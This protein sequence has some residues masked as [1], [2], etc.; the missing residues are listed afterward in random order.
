MKLQ[1]I[2]KRAGV[3]VL[4][5]ALSLYAVPSAS[6]R[7]GAVPQEQNAPRSNSNHEDSRANQV[8]RGWLGIGIKDV[9]ADQVSQL[10]L[11]A[12]GG[13]FV[14]EVAENSPAAK[15]G[16]KSGDVVTEYNGQHVDNAAQFRTLVRQTPSGH[17]V[18]MMVWRDGHS[19]KLSAEISNAPERRNAAYSG[20]LHEPEWNP[21]AF[22]ASPFW[23]GE[24]PAYRRPEIPANT[25]TLGVAVQDLSR[26]LGDY[27]GAPDGQGVLIT[28]VRADSPAAKAGLKAGD[29]I[30]NVNGQRI[31]NVQELR[32][33]IR[34]HGD[35]NAVSVGL[36]RKGTQLTVN[37]T[38]EKPQ[39]EAGRRIPL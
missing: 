37:V 9:T 23:Q 31:H 30:A 25:P 12:A 14:A 39:S 21:E 18:T 38:P 28:D 26:Q 19:Q 6:L 33:Q 11:P 24:N 34:Q 20:A 35:G 7:A 36:I 13:V 29:V 16:L 1:F 2:S 17:S 4:G 3:A 8:H 5:A 22:F 32:E 10:K 27:F 15:A